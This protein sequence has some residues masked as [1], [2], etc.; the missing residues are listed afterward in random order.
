MRG[1]ERR[2]SSARVLG[3]VAVRRVDPHVR[4][5]AG[6]LIRGRRVI[7]V[8]RMQVGPERC[9]TR[10]T[11]E[12]RPQVGPRADRRERVHVVQILPDRRVVQLDA[13][14]TTVRCVRPVRFHDQL[15][16]RALYHS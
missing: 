6:P 11:T 8:P 16:R 15:V 9:A 14:D 1:M 10:V 5:R 12:V 2:V 4:A 7:H 3:P 13:L